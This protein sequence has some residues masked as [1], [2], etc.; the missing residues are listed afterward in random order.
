[1][2]GLAHILVLPWNEKFTDEHVDYWVTAIS[3]VLERVRGSHV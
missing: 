3:D 2:D 1:V